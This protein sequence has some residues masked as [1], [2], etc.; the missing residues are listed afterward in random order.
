MAPGGPSQS[1]SAAAATLTAHAAAA[2][3]ARPPTHSP[4]STQ[5]GQPTQ[6]LTPHQPQ[7]HPQLLQVALPRPQPPPQMLTQPHARPIPASPS[8]SSPSPS[9]LAQPVDPGPYLACLH[10]AQASLQRQLQELGVANPQWR[11]LPQGEAVCLLSLPQQAAQPPVATS[12]QPLATLELRPGSQRK[13]QVQQRQ[14]Q[15]QQ[16]QGQ[17]G[18]QQQPSPTLTLPATSVTQ[19]PSAKIAITCLAPWHTSTNSLG[20]HDLT[21]TALLF[22]DDIGNIGTA[23]N[24]DSA[25]SADSTA[26]CDVFQSCMRGGKS[27]ERHVPLISAR[28]R[29][30]ILRHK[31][32]RVVWVDVD[33]WLRMPPWEQRQWL[34]QRLAQAASR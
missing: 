8:S 3:L 7:P 11:L 2:S 19:V 23:A 12:Q 31:G 25:P 24:A 30:H 4:P 5:P 9:P 1:L 14:Q 27:Q 20:R 29:D 6:L 17:Q 32:W 21:S 28:L 22:L 10:N 13:A 16:Q 26:A 33:C 34:S 18:Q 15:G